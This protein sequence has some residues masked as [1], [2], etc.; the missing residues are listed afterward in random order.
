MIFL[1][2]IADIIMIYLLIE[3][4]DV[5]GKEIGKMHAIVYPVIEIVIKILIIVVEIIHMKKE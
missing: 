4:K 1:T 3:A 2:I 5:N